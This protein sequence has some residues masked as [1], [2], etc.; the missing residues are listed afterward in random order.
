MSL[1]LAT[2]KHMLRILGG[3]L[4]VGPVRGFANPIGKAAVRTQNHGLSIGEV[5]EPEAMMEG[6]TIDHRFRVDVPARGDREAASL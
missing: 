4:L 6:T 2:R 5:D 3:A 1:S